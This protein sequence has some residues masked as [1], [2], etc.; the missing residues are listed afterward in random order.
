MTKFPSTGKELLKLSSD[1]WQTIPGGKILAR[2]LGYLQFQATGIQIPDLLQEEKID[3][4]YGKMKCKS[5]TDLSVSSHRVTP[6][7][8]LKYRYYYIEI[9][10]KLPYPSTKRDFTISYL[11]EFKDSLLCSSI[12]RVITSTCLP[13]I[14]QQ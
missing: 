9:L 5:V 1:Y 13:F 2:H 11:P 6:F 3:G 14:Q 12:I 8:K 7:S 4:K 10:P